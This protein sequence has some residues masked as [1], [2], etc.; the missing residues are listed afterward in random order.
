MQVPSELYWRKIVYKEEKGT[1]EKL[2]DDL[3]RKEPK[4]YENG[5]IDSTATYFGEGSTIIND[6]YGNNFKLLGQI[7][8]EGQYNDRYIEYKRRKIYVVQTSLLSY[9]ERC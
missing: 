5:F 8:G 4:I 3:F 6:E 1:F 2:Y 9:I 7:V